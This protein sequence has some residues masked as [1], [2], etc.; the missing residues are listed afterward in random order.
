[1]GVVGPLNLSKFLR[2]QSSEPQTSDPQQVRLVIVDDHPIFRDGLRRLLETEPDLK[3]VGEASDTA[4][5]M[6]LVRQFK[7]D[8]L[9]TDLCRPKDSGF[10]T[11]RALNAT[12]VR[13]IVFTAHDEKSS[14]SMA[15]KLGARGYVVKGSATQVLL[16]AIRTVIAGEYWVLREPVSNPEQ[17]LVT[18]MQSMH[19]EAQQ[20]KLGL[21]QRELAIIS[22]VVA[23]YTNKE[24]GAYFNI[25]Q[26]AVKHYLSTAFEKLGVSTRLELAL[27][28][29]NHAM[30][31]T[32][33]PA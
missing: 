19:D 21:N 20:K 6:K 2:A 29:I 33:L 30:P 31:L 22:G 23:G 5:A 16:N 4:E 28:A 26:G 7:P 10:E 8:I 9:L 3:V 25:N 17:Y 18:L 14:I 12:P 27:F 13:V 11:L 1:M 32:N 24:I 15:F